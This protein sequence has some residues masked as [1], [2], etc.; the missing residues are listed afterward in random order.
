MPKTWTKDDRADESCR[1]RPRSL[2][3]I[4]Y[5]CNWAI[6]TL[7]LLLHSSIAATPQFFHTLYGFLGDHFPRLSPPLQ[8]LTFVAS[9]TRISQAM[10]LMHLCR[11][12]ETLISLNLSILSSRVCAIGIVAEGNGGS[13][14]CKEDKMSVG[15]RFWSVARD[16]RRRPEPHAGDRPTDRPPV[17]FDDPSLCDATLVRC[18]PMP[19]L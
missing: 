7:P 10:N 18:L 16:R 12:W 9:K 11:R 13:M 2:V 6:Q 15:R 1:T 14:H 5:Y 19:G 8:V 4:S 3:S 17:P